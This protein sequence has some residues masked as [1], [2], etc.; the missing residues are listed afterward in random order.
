[1]HLLFEYSSLFSSLVP[2]INSDYLATTIKTYTNSSTCFNKNRSMMLSHMSMM[3]NSLSSHCL[4]L[5]L[6]SLTL[7][8]NLIIL[9]LNRIHLHSV[10]FPFF[11]SP[12]IYLHTHY[13]SRNLQLFILFIQTAPLYLGVL[14]N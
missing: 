6:E 13:N 5:F 12:F 11:F 7:H 2:P 4:L 9:L 1:M 10:L 3:P 8:P 14:V